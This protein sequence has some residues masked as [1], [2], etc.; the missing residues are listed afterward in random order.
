MAVGQ[1]KKSPPLLGRKVESRGIDFFARIGELK[2]C[3][4]DWGVTFHAVPLPSPDCFAAGYQPVE[5]GTGTAG[6]RIIAGKN[7]PSLGAS[8]LFQQAATPRGVF[9][10]NEP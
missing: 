10:L 6:S 9:A 2:K 3:P 5:N 7:D 4:M 8:P 1:G